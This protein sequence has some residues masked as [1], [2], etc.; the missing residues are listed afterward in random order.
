MIDCRS[1]TTGLNHTP[2]YGM[3]RGSFG[4]SPET[5]F[6]SEIHLNGASARELPS[7]QGAG[8]LTLGVL[9]K[10]GVSTHAAV[11]MLAKACGCTSGSIG[12]AGL[13]DASATTWQFVTLPGRVGRVEGSAVSFV[14]LSGRNTPLSSKEIWGNEFEARIF[15]VRSPVELIQAFEIAS[16]GPLPA[17]FG[18]Q[19]FGG[20]DGDTHLIGYHL[21]RQEWS[22]ATEA[23]LSGRN[24]GYEAALQEKLAAGQGEAEALLSLPS[25]LLKLFVNAYQASVFNRLL[26]FL[27]KSEKWPIYEDSLYLGEVDRFGLPSR[28]TLGPVSSL[29]HNLLKTK[30]LF[31]MLPLPGTNLALLKGVAAAHE[32]ELLSQ[33][34]V[35][36]AD[37]RNS[38]T[39]KIGGGFRQACFWLEKACLHSLGNHFLARFSLSRGMYATVAL[40]EILGGDAVTVGRPSEGSSEAHEG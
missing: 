11:S 2:S 37:F 19:R 22:A 7:W 33:D 5:L 25:S 30:K 4:S 16:R 10:L 18:P 34:G 35:S 28:I 40:Q 36:L 24:G 29:T 26:Q 38:P 3:R 39:G 8:R 15:N 21:L 1:I 9:R 17:F 27:I 13:K 14:P 32:L 20:F 23:I 12:Y 31:P 6:V